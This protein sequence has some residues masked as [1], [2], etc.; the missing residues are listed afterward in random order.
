MDWRAETPLLFTAPLY[1]LL[2]KVAVLDDF[3]NEVHP[4]KAEAI[5]LPRKTTSSSSSQ[6]SEGGLFIPL[7]FLPI[8]FF[9]GRSM[10]QVTSNTEAFEAS[11]RIVSW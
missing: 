4:L 10:T 9:G 8:F 5:D 2:V 6:G 11:K 1:I 7:V 3:N